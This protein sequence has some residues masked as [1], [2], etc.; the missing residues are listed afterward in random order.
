VSGEPALA[1]GP[2]VRRILCPTDFSEFSQ[3]AFAH[4]TA[5][6]HW[7]GARLTLLY[8][9]PV[10]PAVGG[11]PPLV[12]SVAL[13]PLSHRHT[14]GD[15]RAF[16]APAAAAGVAADVAVRDGS[17]GSQILE[18]AR[19]SGADLIVMGTHGRGGF[20]RLVLGSVA[21]KVLRK[22]PCPVLT[23]S[24]PARDRAPHEPPELRSVLCATDLSLASAE[25]LRSALSLARVARARVTV[26]HVV[27]WPQQE[28]PGHRFF[29]VAG[30]RRHLEQE[31][32]LQLQ[33][34]VPDD[35]RE[36]CAVREVV[37]AGTPWREILREAAEDEAEMIVM[38]VHG[39][40][41]LDRLLFGST[42]HHVVREASCPVLT[43]RRREAAR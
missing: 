36:R 22:A 4:A 40:N 18:E 11:F 27:D 35:A 10:M 14:A 21:E 31:A 3:R 9:S 19:E 23:V 17:P 13:E 43:V 6:A 25:A 20:E 1:G 29:D 5:L 28:I 12:S 42:A 16:A 8:V 33:A 38:G 34:A 37:T 41:A 39:R 7:Y 26:L 24:K 15:L 2:E 30:Y 32:L